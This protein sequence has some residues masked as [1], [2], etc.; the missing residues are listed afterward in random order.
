MAQ[1]ECLTKEGKR[2][3]NK[4]VRGSKMCAV[5]RKSCS[6]RVGGAYSAV[7]RVLGYKR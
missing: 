1:C 2:C 6:R 5:H 7:R 3:R 4:A